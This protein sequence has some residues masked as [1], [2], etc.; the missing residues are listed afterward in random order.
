V[1]GEVMRGFGN[2]VDRIFG[3][4]RVLGTIIRLW[5]RN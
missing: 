4:I 3:N 1:E 2:V 5:D